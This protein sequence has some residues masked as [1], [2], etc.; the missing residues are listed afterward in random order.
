MTDKF[1]IT[2]EILS[3]DISV[4]LGMTISINGQPV[5]HSD[6]VAESVTWQHEIDND[7][8]SHE[9]AFEMFG[10]LPDHTEVDDQGNLIKDAMLSICNVKFDDIDISRI[11]VNNAK[12]YHDF[13]GSQA[14]QEDRFFRDLGCNGRVVLNFTTPVYL[15]LLENM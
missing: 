14:P 5:W 12:Y 8:G 15:W 13:N 1:K 2:A 7:A 6:H 3:S 10:K 11:M 4:P 9:L